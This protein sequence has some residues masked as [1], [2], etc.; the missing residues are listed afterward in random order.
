MVLQ[1]SPSEKAYLVSN[2]QYIHLV[3]YTLNLKLYLGSCLVGSRAD[4]R[5]VIFL[6]NA[7]LTSSEQK[8]EQVLLNHLYIPLNSKHKSWHLLLEMYRDRQKGLAVC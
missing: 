5:I 4:R 8:Q 2:S 1:I 7:E 6:M 3:H